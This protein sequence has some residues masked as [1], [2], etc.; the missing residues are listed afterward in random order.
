MTRTKAMNQVYAMG[1]GNSY[2]IRNLIIDIFDY[3]EGEE[4][5]NEIVDSFRKNRSCE[6]C[7]H[8]KLCTIADVEIVKNTPTFSCINFEEHTRGEN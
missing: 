5:I 7:M 3:F 1:Q 6:K 8:F 4:R 2:E